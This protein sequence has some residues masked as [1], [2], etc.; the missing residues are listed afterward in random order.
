MP[1]V[2]KGLHHHQLVIVHI[3]LDIGLSQITAHT[4]PLTGIWP[5]YTTHA[6]RVAKEFHFQ[7]ALS[8]QLQNVTCLNT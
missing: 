2:S 7:L 8:M 5:S 6:R 1:L 3:G 4:V